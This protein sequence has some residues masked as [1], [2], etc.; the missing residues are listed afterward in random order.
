MNT[1]KNVTY[2]KFDGHHSMWWIVLGR[3]GG[4]PCGRRGRRGL[5]ARL[6]VIDEGR[7]VVLEEFG[8]LHHDVGRG[9]ILG[10]ALQ[11]YVRLVATTIM[12]WQ[13]CPYY[14]ILNTHTHTTHT[15]KSRFRR[16]EGC[17]P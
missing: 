16:V 12:I 9:S 8:E 13:R 10:L 2:G 5:D 7:T 17:K 4:G 11:V 3:V 1:A 15:Q 14:T 6:L